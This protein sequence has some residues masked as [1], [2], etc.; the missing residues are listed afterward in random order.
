MRSRRTDSQRILKVFLN[1]NKKY[2]L[3]FQLDGMVPF[4][5]GIWIKP[6]KIIK[7]KII[8]SSWSIAAELII[9][10]TNCEVELG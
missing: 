1:K 3:L 5:L 8:R 7:E 4:V 6:C 2:L 9:Y 10:R